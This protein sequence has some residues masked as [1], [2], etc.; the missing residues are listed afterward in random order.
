MDVKNIEKKVFRLFDL[1][2]LTDIEIRWNLS[3][4]FQ[5]YL[6]KDNK[7]SKYRSPLA[8][9]IP[10]TAE[11]GV[12]QGTVLGL[13]SYYSAFTSY[14]QR[15][16][17]I[18]CWQKTTQFSNCKDENTFLWFYLYVMQFII[19]C[20]KDMSSLFEY[21]RN[22]NSRTKIKKHL[23]QEKKV[24]NLPKKLLLL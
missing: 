6:Y 23:T 18:I 17:Y 14:Y 16:H 21:F 24:K 1:I 4:L 5:N 13:V 3:K 9:E 19:Y 20:H 2:I 15:T 22:R 10:C 7:P 8:L 12:P 11:C